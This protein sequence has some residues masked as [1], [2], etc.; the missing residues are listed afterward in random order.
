MTSLPRESNLR[1][2]RLNHHCLVQIQNTETGQ[3]PSPS[4]V[5]TDEEKSWSK[6]NQRQVK[7]T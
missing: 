5:K 6:T 1:N 7:M 4:A 3:L 2:A